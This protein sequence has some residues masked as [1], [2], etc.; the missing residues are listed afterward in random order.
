MREMLQSRYMRLRNMGQITVGDRVG[1][2]RTPGILP[3]LLA[4]KLTSGRFLGNGSDSR[5]TMREQ[6]ERLSLP[7]E[8]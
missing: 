2:S 5:E 7:P 4:K 1:R 3:A 6:G 8:T